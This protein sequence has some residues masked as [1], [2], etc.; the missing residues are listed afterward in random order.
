MLKA[1]AN[2][3]KVRVLVVDDSEQF[4]AVAVRMAAAIPGVEVIGTARSGAEA[5]RTVSE[6][7]PDLVLMDISM[8]EMNGLVATSII[9]A[10][11]QPIKVIMVTLHDV[12]AYRKLAEQIGVDGFVTKPK[13][14][15]ELPGLIARITGA[16][17]APAPAGNP[18]CV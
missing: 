2:M 14:V 15:T 4:L 1:E 13:L 8:P 17:N 18:G 11:L 16:C 3:M 5:V 7:W 12:P 9:K 6:S 10:G